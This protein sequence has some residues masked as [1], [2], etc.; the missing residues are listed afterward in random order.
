VLILAVVAGQP[1][2][3]APVVEFGPATPATPPTITRGSLPLPATTSRSLL[4]HMARQV[5]STGI[6]HHHVSQE[7]RINGRPLVAGNAVVLHGDSKSAYAAMFAAIRGARDHINLEVY[8]FAADATGERMVEL[9]LAKQRAGVQVNL[10]YD[11]IGCRDTPRAIF[12][13]L[14]DAGARVLEFNPI[15]P[16]MVRKRWLL[17]HRDHRKILVVDGKVAFTGGINVSDVYAHRYPERAAART[18]PDAWRETQV[19]IEGP[20]VTEFQRLF[21][22]TWRRQHGGELPAHD[23]FPP[24][25]ERGQHLARVIASTPEQPAHHIYKT[26]LSALRHAQKSIH[27]TNPYFVPGRQFIRALKDAARRGVDVKLILPSDSDARLVLHAGR[28]HYGGLLRA[29]V[30]IYEHQDE[31]LHAKTAVIDGIWST[32]GSTNMDLRSFLHNDEVNAIFLGTDLARQMETLFAHDLTRSRPVTLESW[33]RRP[34]THRLHE[35]LA[36]PFEYWL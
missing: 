9:L 4:E 22:E 23:Y 34:L 20:A 1:G 33:L 11:S 29:G 21:L 30:H 26:F 12:E 13:R 35:W 27:L 3:V 2:C 25:V 14:Q 18:A 36:R 10:I 6:L 5:G 8:I 19:Q 15:N 31:L 16:L 17:N 24:L 32:V 28:S 7:E